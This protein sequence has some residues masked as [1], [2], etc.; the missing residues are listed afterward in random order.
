MLSPI[1]IYDCTLSHESNTIIRIADD[2]TVTPMIRGCDESSYREEVK[3]HHC[4]QAI[5]ASKMSRKC[6]DQTSC[7]GQRG[8]LF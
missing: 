2:N 8:Q 4:A 7:H 1:F 6:Q 5:A 3:K